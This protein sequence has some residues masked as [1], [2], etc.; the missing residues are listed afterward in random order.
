MEPKS[1][2]FI[3]LAEV[4]TQ[5]HAT[6]AMLHAGTTGAYNKRIQSMS[7]LS[8]EYGETIRKQ[9]ASV[10]RFALN[11]LA[12]LLEQAESNM[13]KNGMKVLWA[14]DAT[15]ACQHILNI[16]T[17]HGVRSVTKSKSMLTE[18]IE[19]NIAL[20]SRG[21]DVV[22]TDLGEYILQLNDEPPGHIVAPIIHKSKES[23]RDI[24]VSKIGMPHTDDARE[25]AHFAQVKLREAFLKSD[26]GI[27]GGNF[28][29]A[30]TGSI[31]LVSNEGNAR[32][33]TCMPNVHVVVVG[34]EKVIATVEDYALLNQVLTRSATGQKMAVY[35]H[36]INGP[37]RENEIDGPS[38]VYIIFV[39]NGRSN[40]YNTNYNEVLACIRCGACLNA[41]PV[42]RVVG[43]K[44][45][46]WVYSGP[47]GAVL[48]PLMIGLDHASEL[49]FASSLCGAC[50]E[51]CPV[52]INIP[53][54]L[55]ELRRDIVISKKN[56]RN[57]D[58]G[59]KIWSFTIE[60][61]FKYTIGVKLASLISNIFK[62]KFF[63]HP[64]RNWTRY[65]TVPSIA[66]QMFR[67]KWRKRFS[68]G[69]TENRRER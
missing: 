49:P 58:F 4:A 34:I 62:L 8:W 16:A 60:T 21:I 2:Q 42:Y 64:I 1:F 56:K 41:C 63:D 22:E 19:L 25:I 10:K 47:I 69:I 6:L 5:D 52:D 17:E 46:G 13:L 61:L 66:N 53:K 36:L 65:R 54:M 20:G 51:A 38:Q 67:E 57:L 24:F 9:A 45:Y 55:V 35:T 14:I 37:R 27:T 48:T 15:E 29:I 3:S 18:E 30:E 39:D 23:I 44:T 32:M 28:I 11:N 31:G 26:M 40:I 33:V 7:E 43:G 50:K 59:M 68:N 12:N